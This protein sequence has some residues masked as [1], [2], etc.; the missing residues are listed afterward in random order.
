MTARRV[1]V[2][3][4]YVWASLATAALTVV[5]TAVG[6]F[7]PD[8]YR[9]PAV[10]LPQLYGQD[11]LTLVVAVPALLA[12]LVFAVRGSLRGYVVWL[13]V[14]GYLLYTFASYAFMTAFN[15]LYLVYVALF[16]LTL[17]AF[18]G[19]TVRFDAAALERAVGDHP[20]R[21]YVGFQ[22]LVAVLVSSV[23]LSE[24]LPAT[25][26]GTTPASVEAAS[27]PVNVIH[28]LDLGVLLPAFGLSAYWLHRG[29]SW[30]YVTTAVLL[31]KVA[32]LGLAVL[33]MALFQLR[34]GQTVAAPQLVVFGLLSLSGL[35]LTARFVA[36][37]E[38]SG[39]PA[40]PAS[41]VGHAPEVR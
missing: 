14:T 28:S 27:V 29:R 34:A 6:L 8:F 30:G 5:A 41:G 25:V 17:F 2:P 20:V 11:L 12:S 13:G 9:D 10:F 21:L 26:G 36:A 32:T 35:G 4:P 15:E 23:W 40:P 16:G 19:G 18:V 3:R 22:V 1:S 24:I 7:V 39:E 38:A 33:A 37:I 31:V